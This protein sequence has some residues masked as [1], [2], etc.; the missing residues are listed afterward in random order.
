MPIGVGRRQTTGLRRAELAALAGVSVDY[1]TRLEQGR[2]VNPGRGVLN[3]LAVALRLGEDER[4]H[5]YRLGRNR[6]DR[7]PMTAP[8]VLAARPAQLQLIQAVRPAPAYVLDEISTVLA[9]NRAGSLLMPGLDDWPLPR[10]TLIRYIFTHLA[11]RNVFVSWEQISHDCVADLRILD[12][13]KPRSRRLEELVNELLATSTEFV[14]LWHRYDVRVNTGGQRTFFNPVT[15]ALHL[16][17]EILTAADGQRLLVFQAAPGSSDARLVA[18]LD[19]A[20][21]RAGAGGSGRSSATNSP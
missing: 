18:E 15:G 12:A 5:L 17:S 14:Q 16:A 10:R 20:S 4:D 19:D 3:A 11:A 9:C 13:T 2:D 1:Y 8:D 6:E 7:R 21:H